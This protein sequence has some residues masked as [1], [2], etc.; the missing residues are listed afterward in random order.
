MKNCLKS[1]ILYIYIYNIYINI[2]P[3]GMYI[4]IYICDGILLYMLL[5]YLQILQRLGVSDGYFINH[6]VIL[7][8][9]SATIFHAIFYHF[10]YS[11]R[12][13]ATPSSG[14]TKVHSHLLYEQ[15]P[16][17]ISKYISVKK[18]CAMRCLYVAISPA[19][20][21]C[22]QMVIFPFRFVLWDVRMSRGQFVVGDAQT[23]S[24]GD[25]IPTDISPA[26]GEGL[27][28]GGA[29]AAGGCGL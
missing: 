27:C 10:A 21:L 20:G 17:E 4:Y 1:Y 29:W 18:V 25:W 2:S 7:L 16:G 22:Y 5:N 23:A 6:I 24:R 9:C 13:L 26:V 14:R 3:G 15:L 11:V 19:S 12:E 8:S 28:P